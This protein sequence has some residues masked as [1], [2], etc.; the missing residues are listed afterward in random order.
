[1]WWVTENPPLASYYLALA[2][3]ALGWS[4]VALHFAFLFPA[5]AAILGTHRLA[6][7]FC[8]SPML[9]ALATLFTPVF[10]VSSTT[11]MCDVLM[12][13]F[14]VWAAA[15]WLEGLEEN[16]SGKLFAAGGLIALAALTKYFGACLIP[17]LAVGSVIGQRRFRQWATPLLIPLAAL[18]TYQWVTRALYGHALFSKATDYAQ[19]AKGLFEV[20]GINSGLI[21]LAFTGGCLAVP[22]V[23]AP[24]L[25]RRQMLAVFAG[26]AILAIT[27]LHAGGMMP[28]HY[29]WF[30]G[31][32]RTLVEF[33]VVFWAVGGIGV[34]ALAITDVFRRRDACSW[35][36]VL[37]VFG[38][39]LFTA[40]F[41]WT[42]NGRSLLPLAPAVG[43]LIARRLEQNGLSNRHTFPR[44]AML[45]L[46]ASAA[47]AFLVAQSDFLLA[48]ATRQ[49][50]RLVCANYKSSAGN[51]W[52]QGHWG[53]QYY[54]EQAGAW[55]PDVKHL[56]LRPGDTL[57]LPMNNVAL[58][59]NMKDMVLQGTL[60]V[61]GPRWFSTWN[62]PIGAGFYASSW[63]PLPFAV[64][65]TRPEIV[66]VY[67]LEPAAPAPPKK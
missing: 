36:L 1:M 62:T 57:A 26:T 50:V 46:A 37:W 7:R 9:A 20:S 33:Q 31:A 8:H 59:L 19:Y 51:L 23:F 38:T 14:W 40:F 63:G 52:F 22:V 11:V 5:V 6:R 53:F 39:F 41:N 12:L 30:Q 27:A 56:R 61:S 34:L 3:G 45:C 47:L 35:L 13:A 15:F 24:L 60:F 58:P 67:V 29:N 43:I 16:R 65:R 2:A 28:R 10:L 18:C 21:A 49:S 44:G 42:V 66:S 54:M 48:V 25:W 17:L 64:G 4:E 32:S 55:A